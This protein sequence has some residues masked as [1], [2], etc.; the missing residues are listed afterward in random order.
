MRI[1]PAG[2]LA[3]MSASEMASLDPMNRLYPGV[4]I[5][6]SIE[7][8]SIRGVEMVATF[9]CVPDEGSRRISVR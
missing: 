9:H 5:S 3:A 1:I 6:M 8:R 4:D 2:R 7:L